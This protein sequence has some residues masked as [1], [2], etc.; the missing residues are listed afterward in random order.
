MPTQK[1]AVLFSV[2]SLASLQALPAA[3][4]TLG[5]WKLNVAKSSV[6]AGAK[7]QSQIVTYTDAGNG[8]IRFT[9]TLVEANGD[10][11][12]SSWYSKRD[13]RKANYNS[14]FAD[15]ITL[16]VSG[17][18]YTTTWESRKQWTVVGDGQSVISKDGKQMT[19]TW[20]AVAKT[21][22]RISGTSVF[23]RQ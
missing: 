1:T 23:D 2:L 6:S 8:F 15:S 19:W 3:D 17:D 16:S 5:T 14:D 10:T 9:S 20:R 12:Q 11:I 7:P 22:R 21:G 13:G 4:P 18:L